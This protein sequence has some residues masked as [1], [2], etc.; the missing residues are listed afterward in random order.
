MPS[1]TVR[2]GTTL[3]SGSPRLTKILVDLGIFSAS[4]LVLKQGCLA[5]RHQT[6]DNHLKTHPDTSCTLLCFKLCV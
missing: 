4:L 5:E 6:P 3:A 1:L 2:L